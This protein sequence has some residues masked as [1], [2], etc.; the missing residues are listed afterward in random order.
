MYFDRIASKQAA[1]ELIRTHRPSPVLVT[2]VFILLTS[3]VVSL[4]GL[5][6]PNPFEQALT[7]IQEGYDVYSVFS[8]VFSQVSAPIGIFLGVL[9]NFYTIVMGFGYSKYC[10]RLTRGEQAGYSTLIEGFNVAGRV[11]LTSLLMSVFITLWSMLFVIPGIIAAY[12]YSQA[13]YCLIDD[14]AIG[15]LEAI[16]R[17]KAMMRGQKFNLFV[18]QLTFIGWYFLASGIVALVTAAVA[19]LLGTH[20]LWLSALLSFAVATALDIWLTPYVQL[21][22]ADFHN[23]L[24]GWRMDRSQTPP[25][26]GPELEF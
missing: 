5:V 9:I 2:L 19:A 20:F 11:I 3:G 24:V 25:Y 10:L 6:A 22:T 13:I 14:P 7:Y 12:R 21:V 17:S 26:Q 4:V 8:Y 23:Y 1:K 18:L 15:P 16:R